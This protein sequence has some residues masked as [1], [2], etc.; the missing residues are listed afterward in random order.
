MSSQHHVLI[1]RKTKRRDKSEKS[2]IYRETTKGVVDDQNASSS[3]RASIGKRN[4]PTMRRSQRRVLFC[5]L[6][7]GASVFKRFFLSSFPFVL[8]LGFQKKRKK[9][10]GEKGRGFWNHQSPV[11][12]NKGSARAVAPSAPVFPAAQT[13]S[14]SRMIP[15][16]LHKPFYTVRLVL[17]FF[18]LLFLNNPSWASLSSKARFLKSF[19]GIKFKPL[20]FTSSDQTLPALPRPLPPTF[21]Y[22]QGM[23]CDPIGN[24]RS[25]FFISP[26]KVVRPNKRQAASQMIYEHNTDF[27]GVVGEEEV[28]MNSS[29]KRSRKTPVNGQSRFNTNSQNTSNSFGDDNNNNNNTEAMLQQSAKKAYDRHA[30]M[31]G[32]RSPIVNQLKYPMEAEQT[33]EQYSESSRAVFN[34]KTNATNFYVPPSKRTAQQQQQPSGITNIPL[35]RQAKRFPAP[36]TLY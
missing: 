9:R 8:F 13:R 22:A 31:V 19:S 14:C 7:K 18:L 25:L 21:Q 27:G 6:A 26:D 1:R 2:A 35:P 17:V 30:A 24:Q 11:F 20:S 5:A 15:N 28:L 34:E 10:R 29:A 3:E 23:E 12:T 36:R 16:A 33:R 32:I 4:G